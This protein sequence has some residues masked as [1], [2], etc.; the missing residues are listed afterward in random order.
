MI[1][2]VGTIIVITVLPVAWQRRVTMTK[3][4]ACWFVL[5]PITQVLPK[6]AC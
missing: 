5:M 6:A 1:N 4:H 3:Q 2:S